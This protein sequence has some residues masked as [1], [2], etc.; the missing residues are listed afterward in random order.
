MKNNHYY[1]I[2]EN[3]FENMKE[4]CQKIGIDDK[5]FKQLRQLN[6]ITRHSR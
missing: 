5:T 3:R 1:L 2:K 4:A 6:I